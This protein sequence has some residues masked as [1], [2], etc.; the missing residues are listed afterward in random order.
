MCTQALTGCPARSGSRP[1]ATSRR[2]R[3]LG[4]CIVTCITQCGTRTVGTAKLL[5]A[6]HIGVASRLPLG[7]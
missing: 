3:Q 7:T 5:A 4:K 1:L 2:M 6:D